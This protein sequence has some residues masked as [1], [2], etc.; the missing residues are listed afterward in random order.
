MLAGGGT[1]A[2]EQAGVQL[3]TCRWRRDRVGPIRL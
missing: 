3:Q 1:W 2:E